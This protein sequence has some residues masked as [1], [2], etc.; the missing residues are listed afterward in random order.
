M[1]ERIAPARRR[2]TCDLCYRPIEPGE[3]CRIIRDDCWPE[4]VWFEHIR[5]PSGETPARHPSPRK[6]ATIAKSRE[7][8]PTTR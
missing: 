4:L 2:Q 7:L 8:Q 3:L 1:S 5:C 6:P